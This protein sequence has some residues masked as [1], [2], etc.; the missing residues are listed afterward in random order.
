MSFNPNEV[1]IGR[2]FSNNVPYK[3]PRYQRKYVWNEEQWRNLI[4]DIILSME[5]QG[6]DN[7][8]FIGS[9]IFEKNTNEWIVVDGQQRLTTITIL[10]AVISKFFAMNN[11]A[12][13][14]SGIR[15]SSKRRYDDVKLNVKIIQFLQPN[16]QN[17][18][19]R[20]ILSDTKCIYNYINC[21]NKVEIRVE[22]IY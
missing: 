8:H 10:I 15:K 14:Y 16:A 17:L 21:K 20:F 22:D 19:F 18:V 6:N 9:F 12:N 3:I 7:Y 13:L 1:T 11:K 4:E 5:K 2:E